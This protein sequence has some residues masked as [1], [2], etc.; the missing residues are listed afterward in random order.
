MTG[1]YKKNPR[2][3]NDFKGFDMVHLQGLEPWTP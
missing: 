2:N 1:T 3:P